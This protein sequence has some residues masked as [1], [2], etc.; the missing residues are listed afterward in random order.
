MRRRRPTLRELIAHLRLTPEEAR[1]ARAEHCIEALF[2]AERCECHNLGEREEAGI[3]AERR[4]W[5]GAQP[6]NSSTTVSSTG[7]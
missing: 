4:R 1:D 2:D 5:T 7:R 3:E 6:P